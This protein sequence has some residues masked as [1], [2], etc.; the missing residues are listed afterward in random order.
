MRKLRNIGKSSKIV[1]TKIK[2]KV[3]QTRCRTQIKSNNNNKIKIFDIC[4][5]TTSSKA[6]S[7]DETGYQKFH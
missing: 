7:L 4:F 5:F 1:G 3:F 2:D 6:L